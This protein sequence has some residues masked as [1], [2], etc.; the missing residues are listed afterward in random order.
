MSKRLIGCIY[1]Y[2]LELYAFHRNVS[3]K[4]LCCIQR[5]ARLC[6]CDYFFRDAL[7]TSV[8]YCVRTVGRD[9]SLFV[10]SQNLFSLLVDAVF[11]LLS[12]FYSVRCYSFSTLKCA[13]LT[14]L[15][16]MWDDWS[17]L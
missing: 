2:I 11:K 17:C 3:K 8:Q 14:C 9:S 16:G 6:S 12:R 7:L 5:T 15:T 4:H 1:M 13:V 10:F